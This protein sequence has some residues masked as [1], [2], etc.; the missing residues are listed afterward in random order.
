MK[1][2]ILFFL[3]ILVVT[4]GYADS[5]VLNNQAPNHTNAKQTKIAIQWA[6]SAKEVEESNNKMKQGG[7]LNL[8]S[9]QVV[10][11]LGKIN[12]EIPKNAE[13]FRVLVWSKGLANPDLLTNWLDVIPNKTYT[14]NDEH[15]FPI[16]LMSGMG[17]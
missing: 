11:Q 4:T 3:S 16:V 17:C 15:L 9:L 2:I 10:T 5:F 13:Y 14:L 7:K 8:K 6:N 12:L 1:K